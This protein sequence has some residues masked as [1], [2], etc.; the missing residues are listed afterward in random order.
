MY[1][2]G[3][4]YW[5]GKFYSLLIFLFGG[6]SAHDQSTGPQRT[7]IQEGEEQGS[8]AAIYPEFHEAAPDTPTEGCSTKT[9]CLHCSA[10]HDPEKT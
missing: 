9:G 3:L 8:S 6:E 4:P 10:H 2:D 1:T 7:Q 5:K